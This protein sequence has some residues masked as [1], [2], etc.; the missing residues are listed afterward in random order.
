MKLHFFAYTGADTGSK[1][2]KR[3]SELCGVW[4]GVY[5]VATWVTS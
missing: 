5:R 2:C 3:C 4:R 1:F